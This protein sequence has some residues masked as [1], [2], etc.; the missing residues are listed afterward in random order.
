MRTIG[1]FV[2]VLSA[3]AAGC[4]QGSTTLGPTSPSALVSPAGG[5]SPASADSAPLA[6]TTRAD[7]ACWGEASAA[8]ARLGEMGYHASHQ[9]TPRLGLR[10][11]ARLL[12]SL[13]T[14]PD[15]SLQALGAFLSSA[16]GMSIDSCL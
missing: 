10:N 11:V 9:D 5:L 16:L 3:M 2:S 7:S 1:I 15:D 13:G 8:L 14:L 4:A 6:R 12:Y